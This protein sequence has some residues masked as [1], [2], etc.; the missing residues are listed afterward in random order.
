MLGHSHPAHCIHVASIA[1]M[2]Y[3]PFLRMFAIR[4]RTRSAK[5]TC[6]MGLTMYLHERFPNSR[7]SA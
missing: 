7:P 6:H 1:A 2:H 3:I 5:V 4:P